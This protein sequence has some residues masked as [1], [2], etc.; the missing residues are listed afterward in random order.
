MKSKTRSSRLDMFCEKDVLRNVKKIY[1]KTPVPESLF[2]KSCR[3]QA[4]NF[5]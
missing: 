1:R 3:P 2:K 4:C 5:I